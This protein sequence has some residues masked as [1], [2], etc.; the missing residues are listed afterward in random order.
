MFPSSPVFSD[1][2]LLKLGKSVKCV[3]LLLLYVFMPCL[4]PKVFLG[5]L[6]MHAFEDRHTVIFLIMATGSSVTC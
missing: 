5:I 1:H 4:D 6:E 2:D 3:L